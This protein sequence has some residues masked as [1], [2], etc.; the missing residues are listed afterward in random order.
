MDHIETTL[1]VEITTKSM[2]HIETTLPVEITTKSMDH[3]ET[4]LPVEITTKSMDHIETTLPI[5]L[6]TIPK[7]DE[8]S[9]NLPGDQIQFKSGESIEFEC[10]IEGNVADIEHLIYKDSVVQMIYSS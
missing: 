6:T 7:S 9:I 4:T 10:K 5:D 1:P 8:I 3:T 2:D